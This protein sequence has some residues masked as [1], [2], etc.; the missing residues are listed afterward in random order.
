L[1][2][3]RRYFSPED[4][5]P[6]TQNALLQAQI[7]STIPATTFGKRSGLPAKGFL[8]TPGFYSRESGI[9]PGCHRRHRL[10]TCYQIKLQISFWAGMS[11][12]I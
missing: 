11:G 12:L 1:S 2:P 9:D 4:L 3:E 7:L 5:D 10:P 6:R 8:C